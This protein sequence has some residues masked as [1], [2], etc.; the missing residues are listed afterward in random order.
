[1]DI[2]ITRQQA[3]LLLTFAG[4]VALAFSIR[5]KNMYE[6]EL[7]E[8]VK[9]LKKVDPSLLEPSEVYIVR[10]LFRG[11]LALVAIGTLLQL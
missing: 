5:A 11:G 3:G 2:Y 4:T 6:S 1:M 9:K 10:G 8:V 7:G